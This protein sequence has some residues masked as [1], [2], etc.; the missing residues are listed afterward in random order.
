MNSSVKAATNPKTCQPEYKS[1]RINWVVCATN[2]VLPSEIVQQPAGPSSGLM[3]NVRVIPQQDNE[4]MSPA[5]AENSQ[6]AE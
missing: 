5:K 3:T 6:T 4:K 2:T 1:C